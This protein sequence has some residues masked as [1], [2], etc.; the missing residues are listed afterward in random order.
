MGMG[1]PGHRPVSCRQLLGKKSVA[2]MEGEH[3]MEVRVTSPVPLALWRGGARA[4]ARDGGTSQGGAGQGPWFT[5]SPLCRPV[6]GRLRPAVPSLRPALHFTAAAIRPAASRSAV[7]RRAAT[8]RRLVLRQF[9]WLYL[10]IVGTASVSDRRFRDAHGLRPNLAPVNAASRNPT[11]RKKLGP[12]LTVSRQG[13]VC[14]RATCPAKTRTGLGLNGLR[15]DGHWP[16]RT[17]ADR[18][19]RRHRLAKTRHW[20]ARTLA[21]RRRRRHGLAKTRHWPARTLADRRIAGS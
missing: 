12:A 7:R 13:C 1:G 5:G 15:F 14:T 21:D 17:L 6:A 3:G 9:R 18:R 11:G 20:P 19:R 4:A 2:A 8:A 10:H 16:A